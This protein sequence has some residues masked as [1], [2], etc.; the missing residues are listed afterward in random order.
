MEYDEEMIKVTMQLLHGHGED[1]ARTL[2]EQLKLA[3]SLFNVDD[4]VAI[5]HT[6]Y[7]GIVTGYNERLG[8]LYTGARYPLFVKIVSS[9]NE[10][11]KIAIGKVFEYSL[12]QVEKL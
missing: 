5:K 8:G 10:T 2:E 9:K 11:Y 3:K 1:D 7:T 4:S 12:D 6:G